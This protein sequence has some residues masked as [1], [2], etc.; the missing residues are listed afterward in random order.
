M[1]ELLQNIKSYSR[2][3]LGMIVESRLGDKGWNILSCRPDDAEEDEAYDIQIRDA[4]TVQV[5]G[6]QVSLVEIVLDRY[7]DEEIVLCEAVD[8]AIARLCY[9]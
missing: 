5:K 7:K 8:H 1:E 6:L 9:C 4:G 2:N 3:E